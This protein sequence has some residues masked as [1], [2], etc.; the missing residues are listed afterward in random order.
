MA[1]TAV[2]PQAQVQAVLE[3]LSKAYL[4]VEQYMLTNNPGVLAAADA[5]LTANTATVATLQGV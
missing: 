4:A 3:S 1:F 5:A 2:K